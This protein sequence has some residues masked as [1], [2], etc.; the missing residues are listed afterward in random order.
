MYIYALKWIQIKF[1]GYPK[2]Y[3]HLNKYTTSNCT[4]PNS[5]YFLSDLVNDFLNSLWYE[6]V[7]N[8]PFSC[9]MASSA[10]FLIFCYTMHMWYL[11]FIDNFLVLLLSTYML[12]RDLD[13]VFY[14][15]YFAIDGHG[16]FDN[17][18]TNLI[19]CN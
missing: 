1:R 11:S 14:F 16:F 7:L 10:D 18:I 6:L 15:P 2:N 13:F 5:S 8:Y 19:R 17:S 3:P 12:Y 9:Y 4:R